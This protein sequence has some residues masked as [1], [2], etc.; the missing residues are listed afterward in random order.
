MEVLNQ[1]LGCCRRSLNWLRFPDYSNGTYLALT[2][3][4]V[5][6][7]HILADTEELVG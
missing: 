7:L 4:E 2:S 1:R 5:A 3:L 6:C